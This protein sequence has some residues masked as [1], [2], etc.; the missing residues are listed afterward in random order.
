MAWGNRYRGGAGLVARWITA[1]GT[2]TVQDD[3]TKLDVD[4]S[5]DL[6][7]VTA[8]NEADK[9]FITG[10][11][12][13]TAKLDFIAQGTAG[14]AA[15]LQMVPGTIGTFEYS[16]VGTAVGRPKRGWVAYVKSYGESLP[17]AGRAE[18]SVEFQK[19][20]PAL[21]TGAW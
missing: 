2:Y 15:E 10:I 5:I 3:Y 12:D 19:T 21:Y 4:Q 17:Q 6:I 9:T 16:P 7:D 13:G 1:A 11:K 14:T 20:G 8:G 18:V